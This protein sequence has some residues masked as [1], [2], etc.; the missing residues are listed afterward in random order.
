MLRG[1]TTS[2]G[3]RHGE[4]SETRRGGAGGAGASR[5][6]RRQRLAGL[7]LL[8]GIVVAT[9]LGQ[10]L[11]GWFAYGEERAELQELSVR[12]EGAGLE[13]IRTQLGADTLRAE[14]ERLDDDLEARKEAVGA[15]ESHVR[16]GALPAHLY[17][18]YRA[19][20]GE[21]NRRVESRNALFSRW[22]EIVFRN[23]AAVGRYNTLA[24]SIRGLAT[25]IGEPYYQIPSPVELAVEKGLLGDPAT[26]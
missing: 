26:R 1:M 6:R 24:D 20:L 21:Y 10:Q 25:R 13:V 8:L 2:T 18:A 19:E 5:V 11:Y 17:D 15:Y 23:H 3:E 22:K 7:L 14:I 12:M 9:K 4:R 16:D